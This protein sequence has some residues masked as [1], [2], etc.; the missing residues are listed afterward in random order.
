MAINS[1]SKKYISLTA[2]I[3][4]SI[5]EIKDLNGLSRPYE[6]AAFKSIKIEFYII[7]FLIP[8]C[9]RKTAHCCC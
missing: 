3:V 5:A 4:G 8:F 9:Q 6:L 1:K 7:K 2:Q